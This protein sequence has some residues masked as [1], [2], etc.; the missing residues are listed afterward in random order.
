M[1]QSMI[2]RRTIRR[3]QQREIPSELL[4]ELFLLANRASTMGNMQLYSVIKTSSKE[5]KEALLPAHFGQSMVMNAPLL[6]TFCADFHR[7]SE[8]ALQRKA[9]PGYNNFLS[10]LNAATDTLLFA[11]KFCTAAEEAGLG[12]CYLG[13]TLYNAS[14]IIETLHLPQLVFPVTAV[15]VGW[16][17]EA[18]VQP[19]RLPLASFVHEE[20]YHDYT[21]NS[22]DAF[23][24]EKEQV[25][26]HFVLENGRETLAQVFTDVR[27][28]KS[29]NEAISKSLLLALKRQGFL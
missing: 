6:L 26:A 11:E 1:I 21:P 19:E 24:A 14:Q 8:Y 10:F 25:N 27:Y 7:F 17:D 20:E 22:L 29:D 23:Y 2:S 12:I 13:T 16:P 5:G 18:S 15:T 28:K 4:D 3:Y 9:L